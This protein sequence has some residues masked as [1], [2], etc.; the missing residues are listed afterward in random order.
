MALSMGEVATCHRYIKIQGT[1]SKTTVMWETHVERA[2]PSPRA[3]SL[4]GTQNDPIRYQQHYKVY[5][6][7]YPAIGSNKETKKES[8]S[9]GKLYQRKNVTYEVIED[10][11]TKEWEPEST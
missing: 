3:V 11:G 9:A 8:I 4:Q 7:D 2:F 1:K 6:R 10:V 5:H